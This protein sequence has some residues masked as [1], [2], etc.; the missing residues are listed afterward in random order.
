[1]ILSVHFDFVAI[2]LNCAY[3]CFGLLIVNHV[4]GFIQRLNRLPSGPWGLP[5]VGYLP[6]T[7]DDTY[8]QFGELAVKYGP[9]F[10][11]KLGSYDVVVLADWKSIREAFSS[12]HLL[13]RPREN[14]FGD[15]LKDVSFTEMSGD[16]WKEQRRIAM[17]TLRNVGLG[18]SKMEDLIREEIDSFLNELKTTDE[19]PFKFIDKVKL[20]IPN[21]VS[22]LL[23]GHKYDYDDP[24]KVELEK[25]LDN[26][27]SVGHF[28]SSGV[29]MPWI[30][31][32]LIFFNYLDM[33]EMIKIIKRTDCFVQIE[34]D[35]HLEKMKTSDTKEIEDYIDGFLHEMDKRADENN[36]N[37]NR[38][39]LLRN[40]SAFY[41]AGSST[42]QSTLNWTM[43][44]LAAYPEYQEKIRDEIR[45]TI[46]FD[47]LPNNVDRQRMPFT[48][49]FIYEVHR[50]V[51]LVP[52]NLQRRA[53]ADVKIGD[54]LIPKDT[55]VLFNFWSVH[56]DSSLYPEPD[57]FDPNRFLIDNGTKAVKP[58]HLI[59]FSGGKR[60]CPGESLANLQLFLYV[61]S[62]LQKFKVLPEPGK[63]I[64]FES[65]YNG[66]R[67]PKNPIYVIFKQL[68]IPET[69]G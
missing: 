60:V 43:A 12:D 6:F 24:V 27:D 30:T 48:I 57:K 21:N 50:M 33:K 1:M 16:P 4:L 10:S 15:E 69:K 17:T 51:S 68:T 47:R 11:V 32:F 2:L 20:S 46:G 5:V 35:K 59:P 26:A 40:T 63:Q 56:R 23:F 28:I 64:S 49:S 9:V 67:Q 38:E 44:Y 42:I 29:F 39:V 18:K 3:I 61:V 52:I 45:E 65:R 66:G 53:T 31:K 7:R 25:N 41:S 14:F 13:S 54:K 19:R 8:V 22:I 62:I 34:I 58:Q 55:L 36:S 37:F